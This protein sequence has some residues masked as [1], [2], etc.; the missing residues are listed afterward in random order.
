MGAF[1]LLDFTMLQSFLLGGRFKTYEPF[2]V[3]I[4]QFF[5]AHGEARITKTADTI[6]VYGGMTELRYQSFKFRGRKHGNKKIIA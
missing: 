2:I 4:L 3:L 1:G 5:S 6:S